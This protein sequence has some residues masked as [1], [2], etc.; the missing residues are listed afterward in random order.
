MAAHR[1]ACESAPTLPPP[2]FDRHVG[3]IE[4]DRKASADLL[5]DPGRQIL[6]VVARQ[7]LPGA[8]PFGVA[9]AG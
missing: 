6:W 7:D 4:N 8:G 2:A 5:L 3:Q 1:R 9:D